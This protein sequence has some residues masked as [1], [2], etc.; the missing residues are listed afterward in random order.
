MIIANGTI[1]MKRKSGGGMDAATGLPLPVLE[2]WGLPVEC[3][4]YHGR[5]DL[6]ARTREGES[7]SDI[8]WTILVE[9]PWS[10]GESEEVRLRDHAGQVLGTY[11]LI[12]AEPLDAV[13]Q[14]RLVVG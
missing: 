3:Q 14:V 1:E 13:Q 2:A 9:Q 11:A 4:Y 8:V 6:Q 12:S 7:Y 10:M 5:M